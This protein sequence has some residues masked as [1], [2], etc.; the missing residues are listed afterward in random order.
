MVGKRGVRRLLWALLALAG[1]CTAGWGALH[2]PGVYFRVAFMAI[3][4]TSVMR[5]RVDWPALRVQGLQHMGRGWRTR[6]AYPA[7]QSVLAGLGDHHSFFL[8]PPF[9]RQMSAGDRTTAGLDVAWPERVVFQVYPG[10]PAAEAGVRVGDVLESVNGGPARGGGGLVGF[11][12]AAQ[13]L[14]LVLR[15][16]GQKE[17]LTVRLTPRLLGVN[18]PARVRSLGASIGYVEVPGVMGPGSEFGPRA[19]AAIG[20]LRPPPACGWVVDLRRNYGGNM[21][22]MLDALR[23]ILGEGTLGFF[24]DNDGR[25]PWSYLSRPGGTAG[26]APPEPPPVAVLTSRLTASSGEAVAIS[27]RGRPRARSFGEPTAGLSTANSTIPMVD[28]GLVIVT[29]AR[30][31]DRTGRVYE[32][33]VAPDQPAAIDWARIESDDDPL[34]LEA[35]RWL[36]EEG[37]CTPP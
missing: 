36:A 7:I 28:G 32:G 29:S 19:V 10:G 31:A 37:R 20:R 13:E 14:T 18:L 17:P 34:V 3:R 25:R 33:A 21:F 5:D 30:E 11:P 9:A 27:L 15:R 12:F 26:V 6:A 8:P 2:L 24:V 23:P 35:M 16:A 1:L 22:P 4:R